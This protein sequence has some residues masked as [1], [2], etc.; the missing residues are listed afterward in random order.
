MSTTNK[1][2]QTFTS[3]DARDIKAAMAAVRIRLAAI[4]G[5][6]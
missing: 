2:T 3:Q 6:R 5:Q 1:T 4:A